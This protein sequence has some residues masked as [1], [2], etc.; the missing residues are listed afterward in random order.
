MKV[1]HAKALHYDISTVKFI[2]GRPNFTIIFRKCLC[3]WAGDENETTKLSQ[4]LATH[5]R[6]RRSGQ[7]EG[8]CQCRGGRKR[9]HF[10]LEDRTEPRHYGCSRFWRDDVLDFCTQLVF[11]N[12]VQSWRLEDR[13]RV[14]SRNGAIGVPREW[15]LRAFSL[16][17]VCLLLCLSVKKTFTITF[18]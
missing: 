16:W 4:G 2:L 6:N 3:G 9:G 13:S 15:I 1:A 7:W 18:E 14:I 5:H 10:W 12:A 17:P 8:P 11:W